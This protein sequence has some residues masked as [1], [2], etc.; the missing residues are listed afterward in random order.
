M[1]DRWYPT[2]HSVAHAWMCDHFG[3]INVRY[4][5]HL[6]DD[7]GFVL[8]FLSNVPPAE[9]KRLGVHTVVARTE[10]DLKRKL[11]AGDTIQVRSR[12][13]RLGTKSVSNKQELTHTDTGVV[14]ASQRV[15]D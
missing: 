12:W 3:H 14:H 9:F 6:F 1:D 8:W 7:A 4:Y 10:T 15:V 2:L 11:V 5:A 13:T